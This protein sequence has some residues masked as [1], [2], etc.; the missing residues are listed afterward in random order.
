MMLWAEKGLAWRSGAEAVKGKRGHDRGLA[1]PAP[2][3]CNRPVL[4][5]WTT[6]ATRAEAE[7]LAAEA[8]ARGLAACA[9]VEGPV[10]SHYLWKGKPERA[11][12]FRLCFKLLPDRLGELEAFVLGR[13]PYE[14]PEW[15][16]VRAE[17]VGEKYLS[18]MR[19]ERSHASL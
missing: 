10:A 18:W 2:Q 11:E 6:V 13:H 9:Q 14:T 5:A 17:R 16:V 12:E 4:I 3:A 15:M 1:A 19:A 7:G 8:A